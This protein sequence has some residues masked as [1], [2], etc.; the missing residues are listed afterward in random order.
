MASHTQPAMWLS[1]ASLITAIGLG[2]YLNSKIVGLASEQDKTNQRL[3]AV[4][5]EVNRLISLREDTD[6]LVRASELLNLEGKKQAYITAQLRSIVEDLERYMVELSTQVETNTYS[7]MIITKAVKEVQTM[8][9]RNGWTLRVNLEDY[10]HSTSDASKLVQQIGLPPTW[11]NP[12][13]F[14]APIPHSYATNQGQPR[15]ILRNNGS[16]NI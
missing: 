1:G 6:K 16:N 10:N 3:K 2:V 9:S 8:A 14:Q 7:I 12:N 5:Q 11:G 13:H 4:I 15:G